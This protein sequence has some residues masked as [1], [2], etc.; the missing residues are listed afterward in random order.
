[1]VLIVSGTKEINQSE[2]LLIFPLTC[3]ETLPAKLLSDGMLFL[4]GTGLRIGIL[5]SGTAS[6]R[7]LEE[8][9]FLVNSSSAFLVDSCFLSCSF[10]T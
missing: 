8:F 3:F 10:I 5:N 6:S 9:I 1:M 4:A 7:I 2:N